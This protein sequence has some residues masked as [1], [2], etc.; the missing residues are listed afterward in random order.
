MEV[1]RLLNQKPQGHRKLEGTWKAKKKRAPERA[2]RAPTVNLV[3]HA[4]KYEFLLELARP[5]CGLRFGQLLRGHAVQAKKEMDRIFDGK[6][7]I[8]VGVVES[9]KGHGR[10]VLKTILLKI[11]VTKA[12]TLLDSGAVSNLVSKELVHRLGIEPD[13]TNRGMT[14]ATREKAPVMETLRDVPV[15]LDEK[16][17]KLGLLAVE[18]YPYESSSE[19]EQQRSS[20]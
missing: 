3:G 10:R 13:K 16:I 15:D 14:D 20:T 5:S 9:G 12:R 7:Q 4:Q 8:K 2:A 11:Y 6:A 1:G 17:V 19:T 18:G